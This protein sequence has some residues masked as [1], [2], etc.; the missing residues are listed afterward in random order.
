MPG[1][2]GGPGIDVNGDGSD[3]LV[4]GIAG[5]EGLSVPVGRAWLFLGAP[6]EGPALA[7]GPPASA[8]VGEEFLLGDAAFDGSAAGAPH[9]C[10]I[11]WGD[12]TTDPIAPCESLILS[13]FRHVFTT[14]GARLV[15]VRVTNAFGVHAEAAVTVTAR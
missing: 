14:A 11:A 15:R 3:D 12:G 5:F 1:E 9:S 6:A 2:A 10:E 7:L 13:S 4:V 8:T